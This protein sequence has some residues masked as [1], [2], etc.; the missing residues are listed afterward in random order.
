MLNYFV[1]YNNWSGHV[2]MPTVNI[3]WFPREIPEHRQVVQASAMDGLSLVISRKRVTSHELIFR[4]LLYSQ[5]FKFQTSFILDR[6]SVIF[7]VY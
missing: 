3:A 7:S 1:F 2:S 5:Q 4:T 6:H